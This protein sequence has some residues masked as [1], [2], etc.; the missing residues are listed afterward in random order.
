MLSGLRTHRALYSALILLALVSCTAS[1]EEADPLDAAPDN[2]LGDDLF[3]DGTVFRLVDVSTS[4]PIAPKM[5][6]R[7]YQNKVA[8]QTS[9]VRF[10]LGTT[11]LIAPRK[12]VDEKTGKFRTL[13]PTDSRRDIPNGKHILLPGE[14]PIEMNGGT[15]SSPHP[16]I[17]I[18]GKDVHILCAPVRFEALDA[19]GKPASLQ[20]K[21]TCGKE[22]LLREAA[23]FQPLILW[24]PVATKYVSTLGSF[25]LGA[26]GKISAQPA[27]LA[28]NVSL[29]ETGLTLTLPVPGPAVLPGGDNPRR[30]EHVPGEK[31]KPILCYVEP[32]LKPGEPA[33]IAVSRK[34]YTD[35]TRE[36]LTP[37]AFSYVLSPARPSPQ[38]QATAYSEERATPPPPAL[39]QQAVKALNTE[40]GDLAWFT[41]PVPQSH[42]LGVLSFQLSGKAFGVLRGF[43]VVADPAAPL[44]LMPHRL[45]SVFADSE[46][47]PFAILIQPGF[48]GGE[49]KIL[50]EPATAGGKRIELGKV[51]L[52]ASGERSDAR[53][54]TLNMRTLPPGEYRIGVECAGSSSPKR[55]V[56]VV[57]WQRRSTF[58]VHSMAACGGMWPMDDDGL[59]IL[60]DNGM[61]MVSNGGFGS[62]YNT[63][64]PSLD[65]QA[66]QWLAREAPRVPAEAALQ[67]TGNDLLLERLLSHQVRHID[68]YPRGQNFYLEGLSY[69]H[70]YK[71]T[72]DRLIRRLQVFTQQTAEYPSFWGVN[73]TWFPCLFGYAEGGV[74]TDIHKRDRNAALAEN[75]KKAGFEGLSKEERKFY[76]DNKFS[77]D[78]AQRTRALELMKRAVAHWKAQMEF[79]FGRHNRLYNE[80]VRQVRPDAAC[81]LYENAGH[82]ISKR[83]RSLFADMDAITYESYSDYPE[84]PMS[85]SFTTDWGRG[86]FP[87]R[88]L[89]I[90]TDPLNSSE[91]M[92]K[93][94]FHAFGRGAA[95]A[96]T[97][98]P[99]DE[100]AAELHRRGKGLR[101]VSQYGAIA[102]HCTPDRRFAILSTAAEQVFASDGRAQYAYHAMYYH[103]ARLGCTPV[104]IDDE[105]AAASGITD[106]T[107]ALF[108][109]RQRQP[110]EPKVAEVIDAFQKKGGKVFITSD[111][112]VKI[113]GAIVLDKPIKHI[114]DG[115][116]FA[117]KSHSEMWEHFDAWRAPLSKALADASL[118][119]AGSTDPDRGI[120]VCLDSGPVRYAVVIAD[121]KGQPFSVFKPCA[122]LNVSLEGSGWQVR[123]L[124]RQ[125]MLKPAT[126]NGRTDVKVDL[127]TEPA[128][129]LA[130]YKAAPAKINLK[131]RGKAVLGET[132]AVTCDI[133]AEDG[134]S[135]GALP[136]AFEI[137]DPA[138][139]LR[140]T[141]YRAAG[142][143]IEVPFAAFDEAGAWKIVAQELLTGVSGTATVN[144]TPTAAP[145][146]V[147]AT[148]DVHVVNE[149]HVRE[150]LKI[151]GEKRVVV[152]AGQERLLP[153]AKKL[154]EQLS[155][156]GVKARLWQVKPED[157]DTIPVRWYPNDDDVPRLID[158]ESGKLIGFRENLKAFIDEQKRAHVPEKG[159]YG[160]IEPLL[161]VGAD[162]IV[163]SG[164]QIASQLRH[165][166]PWMPTP[167]I[168]GRN[169]GRLAAVFSPFMA[170]RH[171]LAVLANDDGGLEKAAAKITEYTPDK[172]II[173]PP[174]APAGD[175]QTQ[176]VALQTRP[177]PQPFVEY[178]PTRRV[179][180]LLATREGQAVVFVDGKS[181]TRAFVDPAGKIVSTVASDAADI[182]HAQ[183]DASGRCWEL[184]SKHL[185]GEWY[186]QEIT[187]RCIGTDGTLQKEIQAYKGSVYFNVLPTDWQGGFPVAPDG[188]TAGLGLRGGMLLGKLGES[189]WQRYNDV[190]N[191][192]LRDAIR[193][194]RF[195]VGA[196]FSPD[197]KYVLLTLD[198]RPPGWGGMNWPAE[199]P[200]A[201]E[202]VLL[203]AA[204]GKV[205]WRLRDEKNT[206][207]TA[208][209]IHTG[210]GAVS[211]DGLISAF[212]DY[213]GSIYIVDKSGKVLLQQQ[214]TTQIP[215][216]FT[217]GPQDGVG[218]WLQEEGKLAAFGYKNLLVLSDGKSLTRVPVAQLV[219]ACVSGD[220]S[221]AVA[222][223][224]GGEVKAFDAAGTLKWTATPGGIAPQIAAA[225]QNQVLVATSLGDLVLLDAAGK[226]VR[227]TNVVAVA[228]RE[229][230]EL[231]P[232]AQ[233]Q[234]LARPLEYVEPGTL[235]LLK[236]QLGAQ[237]VAAWKP[238]AQG[239]AAYGK[240]FYPAEASMALSAPAGAKPSFVHL[241]YRRSAENKSV[242][243]AI[244]SKEGPES[245]VLDLPTPE[246]RVID[247]PV[248]AGA[249]I[250]LSHDGA[251]EVAE[252]SL[253]NFTWPGAN[254]AFV[255][256]AKSGSLDA[257]KPDAGDLDGLLGEIDGDSSL[258][259][260]MK[261]CKIFV[262]NP[263]V[264]KVAGPY[265]KPG[266]GALQMVDGKRFGNGKLVPWN[267]E[268]FVGSWFTIDLG[269]ALPVK[270]VATYDRVQKQSELS[271]NIAVFSMA[272]PAE[273]VRA[274]AVQNDQFWR[275]FAL[276]GE[277]FQTLGVH[278]FS[279]H[280]D[281]LSEIEAYAAPLK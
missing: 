39:E 256:P 122:G 142:E 124:A 135:M 185:G 14:I 84:W 38:T 76:E 189:V 48:A 1:A 47:A 85:A 61:E 254:L 9:P 11:E 102:T 146:A 52:P 25:A 155:A 186:N 81:V 253:W 197:S 27:D 259:G 86:N 215:G 260:K 230:H 93:S 131:T 56:K 152:E 8:A 278:V 191:V 208:Y 64:L 74:D 199:H 202:T 193:H 99:G 167:S 171:V 201:S 44:Q 196:S 68:F 145:A 100:P 240:T 73:Y 252:F 169:Q 161:M 192:H 78:E 63:D 279:G 258:S 128:T 170:G 60:Q 79:G 51:T 188:S 96:G 23:D 92:M 247:V 232:G 212:A 217:S 160:E 150:F 239:A 144:V 195:P 113:S 219:S 108:I 123:D 238:A 10:L 72:V 241:V 57:P 28:P 214:I 151:P 117:V 262:P 200:S 184:V 50:G 268:A 45:R 3:K 223:L 178:T 176:T 126:A 177:V 82:D 205:L 267:K 5:F 137:V 231:K 19:S 120:V 280:A 271:A 69:H 265:L 276:S 216:R 226:E 54:F 24:I 236:T 98:M 182:A 261:D 103:L 104:I 130:L 266:L 243:L 80:A 159:G 32:L 187:L 134:S 213:L 156:A 133:S 41:L 165:V 34:S 116:G 58:L 275:V 109:V 153:L 89:W 274:G 229:K 222:G 118:A 179:A 17:K 175:W 4:E 112:L 2:A 95:G 257:G 221:F 26:D 210:Y 77:S 227:R 20:I 115:A 225:G 166:T 105:D 157:F 125:Q 273:T 127:L 42:S 15:I 207:R 97:I 183:I 264:D 250:T 237:Q 173:L 49:A 138:G 246:Y 46:D 211:K 59:Q 83:T 263:D 65:P 114:W 163:F 209:A 16:A 190:P 91:G 272:G 18:A 40:A 141:L 251:L 154:I 233:F 66:A 111:S 101:F 106:G 204:S 220:G 136:V 234:R 172:K 164:G 110:L 55:S 249:K 88:P 90:T 158:V 37:A 198:T 245:F 121:E 206:R 53:L 162:C 13:Y 12:V 180:R 94:L 194:P 71:P 203:D 277:K 149:Q 139:K 244:E 36:P 7:T 31:K 148:G 269:K 22:P 6:W 228:D 132:L 181:D 29:R 168:P 147:A 248:P 70:S 129:V 35:S 119:P 62:T 281:G 67:T 235:E 270:Y 87:G 140:R 174:A 242:T 43:F 33:R 218:V 30:V 75:L 21:V 107:K 224:E 255:Q 143:Q